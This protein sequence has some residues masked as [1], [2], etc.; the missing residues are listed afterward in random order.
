VPNNKEMHFVKFYVL[1]NGVTFS[2][3]VRFP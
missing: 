2:T 3:H 1:P